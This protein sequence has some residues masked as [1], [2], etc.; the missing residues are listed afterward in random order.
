MTTIDGPIETSVFLYLIIT[1]D[2]IIYSQQKNYHGTRSAKMYM[3]NVSLFNNADM[4]GLF[5]N[6]YDTNY[7]KHMHMACRFLVTISTTYANSD[8]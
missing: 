4:Y 6:N 2:V 7:F 8:N 5:T 1:A 3:V